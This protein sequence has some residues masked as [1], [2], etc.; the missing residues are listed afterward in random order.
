MQCMYVHAPLVLAILPLASSFWTL[1]PD[2][3][4]GGKKKMGVGKVEMGARDR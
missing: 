2:A 1:L 3:F 4:E